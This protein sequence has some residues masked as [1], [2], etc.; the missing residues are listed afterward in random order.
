[1]VTY[2][3]GLTS[4]P[5]DIISEVF[6]LLDVEA[7]KSCSL[8]GKALF[9]L[10]KPFIHRTLHLTPWSGYPSKSSASGRRNELEGLLILGGRGLLQHTRYIMVDSGSLLVA[11]DLDPHVQHLHTIT[12]LKSLKVHSL[13]TP[14]FNPKMEE[15]FGA[16]LGTLQSLDL[17]FPTGDKEQILYFICQFRNLRDLKI[18]SIPYRNG[19]ICNGSPRF[20]IKTSPPLD[21]TL[22]LR[23]YV[24]NL[25]SDSSHAQLILDNLV[26]L[27]SGLKFRT[28]KLRWCT[29]HNL[30][31]L[32]DACA[33]T[34][35]CIEFTGKQFGAS[36]PHGEC[37]L[38]IPVRA[39]SLSGAP[40]D[41][42]ISFK[43]HSALRELE[44]RL[45][46][47]AHLRGVS[48]WISETLSTVTSR[49]FAKL[50]ISVPFASF[51]SPKTTRVQ[52]L[53]WNTI[54]NVLNQL[55][56]CE[57]VTLA[58]RS[59]DWVTK[60]QLKETVEDC[61]PFMCG[62][63]KVLPSYEKDTIPRPRDRV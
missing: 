50:T 8:T 5:E 45:T 34:L 35:E 7:L 37:P 46:E 44:I 17:V 63:G 26:A 41:P 55:D 40:Q 57:D 60:R 6:D 59:P 61:F 28:L 27:P 19:S 53:A 36:S 23:F 38:F 47:H 21:G 54:D 32:I 11:R 52:L 12:N 30:Q 29:T 18:D 39:I 3:K 48:R 16:F 9:Y 49:G 31:P 2:D 33:S 20:N 4:L 1:M 25:E 62:N 51:T 56:L 22:D 14:S 43:R 42:Q 58:V 10:A 24:R 13:D 15:Y